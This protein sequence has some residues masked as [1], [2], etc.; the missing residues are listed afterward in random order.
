MNV[1]VVIPVLNEAL[2][3]EAVIES[4][5]AQSPL[6]IVVVDGGSDDSTV[7]RAAGADLIL[8][9]APG[10]AAQQNFGA[11]KCVG[12]VI[13]FLHADCHLG[14]GAISELAAV[15]QDETVVGG[16][17]QQR[18]DD[19]STIYRLVERGNNMRAQWCKWAYGDQGIFVRRSVFE[20]LGG[21]REIPFMEDLL[22]SKQL[23]RYG[24]VTQLES[25][26][27]T[28]ARHWQ[29]RGVVR[30][31]LM[32]WWLITLLH[33]GVSPNRLAKF[34]PAVR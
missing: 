16:S 24:K 7:A 29:K 31:T 18:I 9:S 5:R 12:D 32:N 21:F 17:F 19:S 4:T 22:L 28:S 20:S 30:Q 14:F 2:K 25:T 23:K 15:M 10:R 6:E 8:Q 11:S 13:L 3:I 26:V 34:C 27:T 33:C 1:S